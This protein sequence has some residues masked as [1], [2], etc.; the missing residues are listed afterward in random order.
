MNAERC[1]PRVVTGA[2]TLGLKLA[3]AF[4][5]TILLT[6]IDSHCTPAGLAVVASAIQNLQKSFC[7]DSSGLVRRAVSGQVK[8]KIRQASQAVFSLSTTR[9]SFPGPQPAS[10]YRR[11]MIERRS[12]MRQIVNPRSIAV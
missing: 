11:L 3:N 9:D 2:P 7:R 10:Q 5:V 4:G 6:P 1:I 12:L 8:C